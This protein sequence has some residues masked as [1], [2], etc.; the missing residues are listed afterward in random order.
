MINCKCRFVIILSLALGVLI[1]STSNF[2]KI[3]HFLARL[4]H[5]YLD[6][7]EKMGKEPRDVT[8][9]TARYIHGVRSLQ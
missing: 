3:H 9:S 8:E 1:E 5:F 2:L 7:R 6:Y 4:F